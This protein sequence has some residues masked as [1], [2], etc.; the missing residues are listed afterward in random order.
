MSEDRFLS[1]S[2][3]EA[4]LLVRTL[5]NEYPLLNDV[6]LVNTA[7]ALRADFFSYDYVKGLALKAL[8]GNLIGVEPVEEFFTAAVDAVIFTQ[9]PFWTRLAPSGRNHVFNVLEANGAQCLRAAGLL[10]TDQRATAWWDLLSRNSRSERDNRMLAQG[11]E[12]ERLSL[13]YEMTRLKREGI[14]HNPLWVAI[15]DNTVGYDILSFTVLGGNETNLLIEV[16]TS[17]GL[18]PR[19]MISRNEWRAAEQFGTAFQFHHWRIDE[20]ILTILSVDDLRPHMPENR[21]QGY[22]EVVE[23]R[24]GGLHEA[25]TNATAAP[26]RATIT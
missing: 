23:V 20:N 6:E 14:P 3:F 15:E 25:D 11:R 7:K 26:P 19:M 2:A 17:A 5:R 13:A 21:G 24:L 4:A 10:G 22:W 12:G 8:I 16:K 9:K 18:A 1:M